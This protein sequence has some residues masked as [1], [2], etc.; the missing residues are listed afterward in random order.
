MVEF[1]LVLP[2]LLILVVG[3]VEF[4][5]AYNT[6][7]SLQAAAR[8]GAREL[9]LGRDDRVQAAIWGATPHNPDYSIVQSCPEG[10]SGDTLQQAKV[11]VTEEFTF[12]PALG[13]LL[14]S[15]S[16]GTITLSATG[17]MRCGL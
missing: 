5:R 9:A 8:E 10:S 1:A 16:F 4:G 6:K 7:I 3:I 15:G 11:T 2:L 12:V 17:A 13:N 14:G